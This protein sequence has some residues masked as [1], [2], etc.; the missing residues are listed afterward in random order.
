MQNHGYSLEE[1]EGMIPWEREVYIQML[2]S[3]L[4]KEKE[5]TSNQKRL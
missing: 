5:K 2:V 3:H 4:K 1:L